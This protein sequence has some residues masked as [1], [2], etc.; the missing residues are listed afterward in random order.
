MAL[1][2]NDNVLLQMGGPK[3][4]KNRVRKIQA[5]TEKPTI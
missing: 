1:E 4:I 2:G 5:R 3:S